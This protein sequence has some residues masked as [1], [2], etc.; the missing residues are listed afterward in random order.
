V[1][2]GD[3]LGVETF[4]LDHVIPASHGGL[5]NPENL[6]A[7][8]DSCNQLR[9]NKTVEQWEEVLEAEGIV[10]WVS[11][12]TEEGTQA[13]RKTRWILRR[14][15]AAHGEAVRKGLEMEARIKKAKERKA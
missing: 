3:T 4:T 15:W 13:V 7:C 2:C 5:K 8:C 1:W 14:A 6:V 10:D 12:G 9:G 11:V